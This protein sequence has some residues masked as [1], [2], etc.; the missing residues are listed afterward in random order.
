MARARAPSRSPL[1]LCM[2]DHPRQNHL[3]GGWWPQSRDLTVELADLV[4]HFP[5]E[6]GQIARVVYSPPDW[7]HAPRRIPVR[8][9][10]IKAGSFP[11]D[12]AHVVLL[13]MSDR[14][15]LRLLV[16][17]P[18]Y[19]DSQGAEALL[20]AATRG[21][22]HT[23]SALLDAVHD[24]HDVD[25]GDQWNDDGGNWWGEHA[26]GPSFRSKAHTRLSA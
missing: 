19:T 1:R 7:K 26:T 13:R 5:P 6:F 14:D 8:R 16:V 24:N 25:P 12:D 10:Y 15:V 9:G 2:A 18:G 21:N 20:A 11:H 3:D 22:A 17:P 4:D 23:A